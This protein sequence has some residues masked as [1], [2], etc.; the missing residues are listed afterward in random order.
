MNTHLINHTYKPHGIFVPYV[1]VTGNIELYVGDKAITSDGTPCT[2]KRIE[3]IHICSENAEWICREYYKIDPWSFLK[4]WCKSMDVS[5]MYFL[6][7]ELKKDDRQ[8]ISDN[9]P[10]VGCES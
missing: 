10:E 6:Y 7:I 5:S 2:I 1:A 4:K 9:L 8:D 3:R